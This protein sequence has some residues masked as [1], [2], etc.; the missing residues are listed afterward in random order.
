MERAMT[1]R[2]NIGGLIDQ[3][4]RRH[5][6]DRRLRQQEAMR[7]WPE[8]VGHDIARNAWPSSVRDGVLH[9]HAANHAWVQTLH[10][11]RAQIL[12]ALNG[13]LGEHTLN[14][15]RLTVSRE[16]SRR[17]TPATSESASEPRAS[18]PALTRAERE[19]LREITAPIGDPDLRVRVMRAASGLMRL[20]RL[21]EGQGRRPCRR[22]G[23]SFVGRGH[24][25]PACT[26]RR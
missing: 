7:L 23:R 9:V 12:E 25:C 16:S 26:R 14:D 13:R 17:A 2:G 1:R 11:M 20:R 21:R 4:M 19:R 3:V 22:C 6:L 15:L 18:L 10:L 8:V 5:H 24:T